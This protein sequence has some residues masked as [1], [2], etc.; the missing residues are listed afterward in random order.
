MKKT[1]KM[2][3]LECAHCA[4]KME[5]KIKGLEG[6]IY[7]SVN[8]F[9]QKLIIEAEDSKFDSVLREAVKII[10]KIEPDCGVEIK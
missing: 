1:F 7:A 3:D 5:D 6:V 9:S 8:F 2:T 4:A 10:K